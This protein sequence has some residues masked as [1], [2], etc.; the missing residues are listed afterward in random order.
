M[1]V[2]VYSTH[3]FDRPYLEKA[4]QG[5]H[6][7]HFVEDALDKDSAKLSTGYDVVSVFSND[8]VSEGVLKILHQNNIRFVALRSAGYNHVDLNAAK[9]LN[10]RVANVPEYSPYSVA[11]HAVAM[12]M[13][14]NRKLYFSQLLFQLQD[15]RLDPLVGFDV[16]KKTVGII[17]TG[18]IGTAFA[19][20]MKGFGCTL[21]AYDI[22]ENPDALVLGVQYVSLDD[23][24][25]NSDIISIHCPLNSSTYH[26]LSEK[27]FSKIKKGSILINT[28]RGA[29]IDTSA[30]IKAIESEQIS[31]ACL[32]VYEFE[33][34][35]YFNDKRN[36]VITDDL[37][38][39]LKSFP[40]VLLTAHQA[41]LTKEAL[42]NI[43][44]TTIQNMTEWEKYGKSSN[45][46]W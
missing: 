45:D 36:K 8:D 31:G 42:Q 27:K 46:L 44:T 29:V 38:L 14:L 12:L 9:N 5:I 37:F 26:L 32:D 28:A 11:E 13:A 33:K 23:L 10:I 39:K 4:A 35:L 20:I 2:L 25:S 40:N 17:G 15:F 30:L 43:A 24:L 6:Q 22:K 41:F 34:G 18:K 7:L 1:K 16:H 19:R 21:L 3:S